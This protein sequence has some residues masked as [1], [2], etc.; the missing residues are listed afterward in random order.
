M[1]RDRI[2]RVRADVRAH[3]WATLFA[4]CLGCVARAAAS[5]QASHV[6]AEESPIVSQ[7]DEQVGPNRILRRVAINAVSETMLAVSQ[8]PLG[9]ERTVLIKRLLPHAKAD[10][11]L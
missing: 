8:G 10:P 7:G 6:M 2:A 4:E 1:P 5:L 9:F 3:T 11:K